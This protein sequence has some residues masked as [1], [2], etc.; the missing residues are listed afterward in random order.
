MGEAVMV[1]DPVLAHITGEL[2]VTVGLALMVTV[3]EPLA[4]QTL[5][6]VMVTE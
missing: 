3:P 4:V 1:A 2:T 6:L 5:A